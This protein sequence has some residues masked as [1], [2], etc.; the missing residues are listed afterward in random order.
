MGLLRA[1]LGWAQ[2]FHTD[3]VSHMGLRDLRNDIFNKLLGLS[4]GYYDRQRTGDLISRA[5]IDAPYSAHF[6]IRSL[7]R[8]VAMVIM[9]GV[10]AG[11]MLA[12]NW[13]LG[14]ISL[15]FVSLYVWRTL[16]RSRGLQ[17]IWSREHA[18]TG[19]MNALMEE[20]LSG[21]RVV[22]TFGAGD[23]EDAKFGPRV[24]AVSEYTYRAER[25]W[26]VRSSLFLFISTVTV[27]TILWFGGREIIAG[28]LT[29]GELT[30]F[31]MY[32][33]LL[34]MPIRWAGFVIFNFSRFISA[35]RR[36]LEILDAESPVKESP[37]AGLMP[38][39]QGHVRFESVSLSYDSSA[40]ALGG[41]SQRRFPA[42]SPRRT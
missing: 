22:K 13:R 7:S 39:V 41:I 3:A 2:L 15:V 21:M 18:E 29:P 20:N 31:I 11:L 28:R 14:V 27:G 16:S 25:F 37:G 34:A 42:V 32:L 23:H 5:M 24:S 6:A 38:R 30:A 26:A 35:E 1:L 33:G 9:L 40:E 19:I 8:V 12:V 17:E 36:D 4:V 10:V